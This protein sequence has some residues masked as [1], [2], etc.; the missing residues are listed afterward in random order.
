MAIALLPVIVLL[1]VVVFS[2]ILSPVGMVA[3]GYSLWG[4]MLVTGT[5]LFWLAFLM[6]SLW[7]G[8][9]M[10]LPLLGPIV[11]FVLIIMVAHSFIRKERGIG[12]EWKGRKVS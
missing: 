9:R 3:S 4:I 6:I 11:F 5:Y 12:Y 2:P 8:Y 10:P 1:L 7:H